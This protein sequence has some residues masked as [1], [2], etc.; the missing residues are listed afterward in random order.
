MNNQCTTASRLKLHEMTKNIWGY[1][2]KTD[3][4]KIPLLCARFLSSLN[5]STYMYVMELVDGIR[6]KCMNHD[7]QQRPSA[8]QVIR[9]YKLAMTTLENNTEKLA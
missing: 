7:P 4:W 2:E 8:V 5:N 1:D 3:I 9:E 6:K